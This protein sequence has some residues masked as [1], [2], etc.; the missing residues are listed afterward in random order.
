MVRWVALA[1]VASVVAS[2]CALP[3]NGLGGEVGAEGG[4]SGS[5]S[6]SGSGSASGANAGAGAGTDAAAGAE[7]STPVPDAADDAVVSA[8]A[9]TV[10]DQDGDG[11]KATGAAC[12]GDDC[13]D[14]DARV[15]PGQTS[16]FTTP[17]ACGGYDYDCD[18]KETLEYGGASCQW[19]TFSCNGDGFAAPVPACGQI[20]TFTSC[21]VPWYDVFSCK[22][23]DGNQAQGCR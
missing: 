8:E 13:C 3:T 18:S 21:S 2:A 10:C 14:A 1:A 9:G 15:H 22:G 5:A 16:F 19:S 12:G 11:H 17:G 6:A 20:G 23:N 4:A 7:A